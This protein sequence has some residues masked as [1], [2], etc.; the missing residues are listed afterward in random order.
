MRWE[1]ITWIFLHSYANKISEQFFKGHKINC[2]GLV[3]YICRNLPCPI[4]RSHAI[5]YLSLHNINNCNNKKDLQLFLWNFHNEVN[6]MLNKPIYSVNDL[7]KY[8]L[9]IFPNI[10]SKFLIE[11]K[12]PY[13]YGRTMD[14]WKRKRVSQ[15]IKN[16]LRINWVHFS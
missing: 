4:C 16:W 15:L 3:G 13:Y 9:A 5:K 12:R 6:S 11:F 1:M 2:C 14:S 7:E 8:D 10:V